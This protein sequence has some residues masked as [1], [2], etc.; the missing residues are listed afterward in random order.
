MVLYLRRLKQNAIE[1]K[2][3]FKNL[4][5]LTTLTLTCA[6]LFAQGPKLP[7]KSPAASVGYTVGLTDIDIEYSSPA[8]NDRKIWGKVV[9]YGEL[10]RAGANAATTIE[11]STDVNLEGKELAAGKYAFFLI[12][13]EGKDAEWTAVF[14]KVHDQWGAYRYD[15]SQDAL[16]VD[17]KP[18]FKSVNQER[19]TYSIHDQDVDKGYIKMAWAKARVYL[20][21]KVDVLEPAL[22]SVD[23]AL[24]DASEEDK[25]V[26]LAQGASFLLDN[27]WETRQ[28]MEWADKS[29][30]LFDHSWNW[31][32]KA[33]AQAASGDYS[34]ALASVEK[35][36]Q[37]Y[38]AN[39][40]DN[41]YKNA[42]DEITK[43]VA[44]WKAKAGS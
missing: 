22:A 3:G 17:V 5:L 25:W 9:P 20:R 38:E 19:L 6:A 29:T 14:N 27:E 7:Q 18:Q 15:E 24:E 28:A 13:R 4:L 10:W 37:V 35:S 43:N 12:T 33:R 11:F 44:D 16:R 8:V 39:S 1:M 30:S 26:I 42:Q 21:F 36:K 23:E 31:Y 2:A 40:E 32:I 41:F 34:G